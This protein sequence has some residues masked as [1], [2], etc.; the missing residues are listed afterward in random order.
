[1]PVLRLFAVYRSP[2]H[3]TG[4]S[5]TPAHESLSSFYTESHPRP[6]ISVQR[7]PLGPNS[8]QSRL[9]QSAYTPLKAQP[10][11][12]ARALATFVLSAALR[13][14][15]GRG[16]GRGV[17]VAGS[18]PFGK[19]A[20]ALLRSTNKDKLP[21]PAVTSARGSPLLRCGLLAAR[22]DSPA[23]AW[24]QHPTPANALKLTAPHNIVPVTSPEAYQHQRGGHTNTP[25]VLPHPSRNRHVHSPRAELAKHPLPRALGWARSP[26]RVRRSL[27][28]GS[29][30]RH[31][32]T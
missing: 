4:S 22:G 30:R 20:L 9:Q 1:M 14:C 12:A 31:P 10:Q 23:C 13:C 3:E 18:L 32:R 15:V 21:V 26:A 7:A 29:P 25:S 16:G 17:S 8:V 6:D 5:S 24:L 28:P 19:A 11:P 2:P 27:T